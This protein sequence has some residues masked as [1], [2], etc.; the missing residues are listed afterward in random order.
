MMPPRAG[1][2][3]PFAVEIIRSSLW[4]S[5]QE[6]AFTLTRT[7]YSPIIQF[8][9]DF[10]TGIFDAQARMI[11][12][13]PG[14]VAHIIPMETCVQEAV[15]EIG[16]D[17]LEP[18]DMVISNDPFRGGTHLPDV[19]VVAAYH[20]D[21]EL[22]LFA[23]N[24]AHWDDIGGMM[25]GSMT[26][27]STELFQEGLIIPPT[28]I[29]ERGRIRQDIVKM[30][31]ENTRLPI[32]RTGDLNAQIGANRAALKNLD[33]LVRRYGVDAI[34]EAKEHVLH[35]AE[36]A[37]REAISE[38]PDG[39]YEYEDYMDNDGIEQRPL[40][41]RCAVTIQGD[42]IVVDFTGSDPMPLGPCKS[43]RTTTEAAVYGTVKSLI[44]HD[45]P[46]NNGFFRPIEVIVPEGAFLNPVKPASVCGDTEPMSR[47]QD[48]VMGIFAQIVPDRVVACQ[49]GSINHIIAG[50]R[51]PD[52]DRFVLYEAPCGGIGAMH[53][54]DGPTASMLMC[55]DVK[56]QPV[57]VLE[58]Q[59]PVLCYGYGL[60]KDSGGAGR[61]RGGL[62]LERVYEFLVPV[63]ASLISDR[64]ILRPFGVLGGYDAA[65]GSWVLDPGEA[66]E[67]FL[68]GDL[69]SKISGAEL[70]AGTVLR[71]LTSGGGGYGDPLQR[72]PDLVL[73]DVHDGWVSREAAAGVYGVVLTE[74]AT[75]WAVD[76]DATRRLRAERNA[77][78][79]RRRLEVVASADL[80]DG[81]ALLNPADL[82]PLALAEGEWASL[83]GSSPAPVRATV[84]A[85]EQVPVGKVALPPHLLRLLQPGGD[86][87]TCQVLPAPLLGSE[88]GDDWWPTLRAGR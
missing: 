29:V 58:Q 38:M 48:V 79:E 84:Q 37:A 61:F 52:G 47:V 66:G 17:S 12:Q 83:L 2:V 44:S 30:I 62:G 82:A 11:V 14:L 25:P 73:Q 34:L 68:A 78:Q 33:Q 6:M 7:A 65:G 36:E 10:S 60:R 40:R 35:Q 41:I 28:K 71:I 54:R 4:S 76:G 27:A 88:A 55:G 74:A 42:S 70:P 45:I 23:G 57:E 59:H 63:T 75:G 77:E 31:V 20:V 22:L 86:A 51:W 15:A 50:G 32:A 72:V 39:R 24:R 5:C 56:N 43:V 81:S 8:N 53:D 46:V 3:D 64:C 21:G 85:S 16:V 18:G 49:Y 87:Q 80:G 1:R 69:R 26:G 9:E 19:A 67:R 13:G